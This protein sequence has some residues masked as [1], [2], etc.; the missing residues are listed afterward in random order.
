[1]SDFPHHL[2][3]FSSS[4]HLS[5][6]HSSSHQLSHLFYYFPMRWLFITAFIIINQTIITPSLD[7]LFLLHSSF[8]AL[9]HPLPF[10]LSFHHV[11]PPSSSSP[12]SSLSLQ[13]FTSQ[14]HPGIQVTM[15]TTQNTIATAALPA[16]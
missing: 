13:P 14:H 5:S 2:L 3:F 8:S 11:R 7:C 16:N 12:L 1:M 10:L 9:P 15:A 4:C 6:A